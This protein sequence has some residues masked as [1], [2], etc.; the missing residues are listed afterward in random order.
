M[1]N[2]TFYNPCKVFFGKDTVENLGNEAARYGK[3]VLV[4]TGGG[5]V[6][7]IG[8]F[9]QVLQQL[10]NAGVAYCEISGV[11]P[12]PRLSLIYEAIALCKAQKVDFILAVGGGSVI[13]AA[14]AIAA[15][16]KYSGDVWD[17]YEQRAEVKE[18]LPLGT[19]LTLAATGSEMNGNSV[20]TNWE[21]NQKLAI[22]S[23][24][25]IPKFSILDPT[26]TFSV[27]R[28]QTVNGIVDIMAHVFEQY[29]S[30][31]PDTAIQDR[32]AESVLQTM[33]ETAPVVL[34]KPDN[35]EARAS[36]MWCGT[37]ALNS[38]LSRGKI[39]DWATHSIEHEVS[40]IYD[41]P[42]GAGLAIIFP[43]WMNYVLDSGT[44]KFA[45]YAERVWKV[46][47]AGK[48]EREVALE[49]IR[50][51]REFFNSIGAPA[52]LAFYQIGPERIPE[53][54]QKAVCF[55]PIG[56]YRELHQADVEQILRASL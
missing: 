41:I 39:T 23:P 22:G 11:Q 15:G 6:K 7:K 44:A 45:Q 32:L 51:T 40:A 5:S 42:H 34:K 12:N 9:D 16:A 25:L 10:T 4:V 47:T 3:N 20:V 31:T 48:S 21:T 55:G 46:E 53:M 17:F 28:D 54:A 14:K 52:T 49:G 35:Y 1:L 26:L 38:L 37:L 43:N 8:L 29:F 18:A 19:I 56:G 30:L 36:M 2:F 27:S 33:I 24:Y 13:D 50:R